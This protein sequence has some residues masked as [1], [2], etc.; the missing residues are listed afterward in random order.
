[1]LNQG[2]NGQP[3]DGP[4]VPQHARIVLADGIIA[5]S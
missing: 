3:K 5:D 4:M 1:M 2:T